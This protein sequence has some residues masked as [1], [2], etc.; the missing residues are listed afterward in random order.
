LRAQVPGAA[1]AQPAAQPA[2]R[3]VPDKFSDR[4]LL[5]DPRLPGVLAGLEA[6]VRRR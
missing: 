6:D 5:Y 1:A 3:P 2:P 4:F